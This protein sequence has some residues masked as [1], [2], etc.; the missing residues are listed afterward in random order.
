MTKS[1]YQQIKKRYWSSLLLQVL[2]QLTCKQTRLTKQSPL[3]RCLFTLFIHNNYLVKTAFTLNHLNFSGT[4]DHHI[5]S[6]CS[7]STYQLLHLQSSSTTPALTNNI[8]ILRSTRYNHYRTPHN[9]VVTFSGHMVYQ[10]NNHH[11]FWSFPNTRTPP[12]L[13]LKSS[14][15]RLFF[16]TIHNSFAHNTSVTRVHY[17]TGKEN[18]AT[19]STVFF[20]APK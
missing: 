10:G 13:H 17:S 4:T 20:P 2:D 5:H 15:T 16:V 12:R 19:A 9:L 14:T 8:W 1:K 7:P 6:L 18:K 3:N 11:D